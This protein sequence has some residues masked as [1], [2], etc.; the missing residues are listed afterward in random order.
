MEVRILERL[1]HELRHSPHRMD[2]QPPVAVRSCQTS[3]VN[4]V[5]V[6]P[7]T[8]SHESDFWTQYRATRVLILK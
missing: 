1:S 8:I 7:V 3:G 2:P 5:N 4:G 6:E